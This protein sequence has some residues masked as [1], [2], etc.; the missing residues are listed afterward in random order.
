MRIPFSRDEMKEFSPYA[1][2]NRKLN[3][4]KTSGKI[5]KENSVTIKRPTSS[6]M[7]KTNKNE[8]KTNLFTEDEDYNIGD[9]LNPEDYNEDKSADNNEVSFEQYDDNVKTV[10][11]NENENRFSSDKIINTIKLINKNPQRFKHTN[12]LLKD[13]GQF[14]KNNMHIVINSDKEKEKIETA[15]KEFEKTEKDRDRLLQGKK[16]AENLIK[17]NDKELKEMKSINYFIIH[18][19]YPKFTNK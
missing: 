16:N 19:L 4:T 10:H 1:S 18:R 15:L 7:L 8:P 12:A 2:K 13:L 6:K 3:K 14:A 5:L 17:R 11:E 9:N